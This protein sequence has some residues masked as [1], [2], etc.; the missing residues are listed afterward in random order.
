MFPPNLHKNI[1]ELDRQIS[2]LETECD[3]VDSEKSESIPDKS[4]WKSSVRQFPSKP[5]ITG[6]SRT[7]CSYTSKRYKSGQMSIVPKISSAV[8]VS[9]KPTCKKLND[10]PS[11]APTEVE[12]NKIVMVNRVNG[13]KNSENEENSDKEEIKDGKIDEFVAKDI[14][15]Q[16]VHKEVLIANP[17]ET[18]EVTVTQKSN[19]LRDDDTKNSLC[20]KSIG[21]IK[22]MSESSEEKVRST[23][24]NSRYRKT[25]KERTK[26]DKFHQSD[27][28]TDEESHNFHKMD[29][30]ISHSK[31][32][33]LMLT[34]SGRYASRFFHKISNYY[35]Y[36]FP[37]PLFF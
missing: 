31:M 13:L 28:T 16:I 26:S 14:P 19:C 5:F 37:P 4:Y 23:K 15:K 17:G 34:S 32:N 8:S 27:K 2:L 3:N 7:T 20:E 29:A 12:S 9:V 10:N 22:E 33:A 24:F 35:Y 21:W 1:R 30:G 11:D 36:Y 18:I 6:P 25:T